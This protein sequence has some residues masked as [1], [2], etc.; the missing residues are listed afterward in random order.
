MPSLTLQPLVENS[1]KHGIYPLKETGVVEINAV[2]KENYLIITIC[3]NGVGISKEVMELIR[4]GA[5]IPSR[6]LGIGLNNVAQRLDYIYRGDAMFAIESEK[7][8]GTIVTLKI[9]EASHFDFS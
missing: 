3:D 7:G 5:S 4:R 8:K 6:G 2:V 1:I 9:P